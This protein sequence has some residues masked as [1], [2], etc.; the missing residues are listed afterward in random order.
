MYMQHAQ[1]KQGMS[2]IKC[3]IFSL[4]FSPLFSILVKTVGYKR[5]IF[6]LISDFRIKPNVFI[7]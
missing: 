5:M 3:Y 2:H 6:N 1:Q 7:S 4:P